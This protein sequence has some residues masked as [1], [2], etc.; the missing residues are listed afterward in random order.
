MS[1]VKWYEGL[2]YDLSEAYSVKK[3]RFD[4]SDWLNEIGVDTILSSQIVLD[5]GLTAANENVQ[6]TYVEYDISCSGATVG[7]ILIATCVI[8]TAGG[9]SEPRTINF[10]IIT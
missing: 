1:T 7:D 2:E 9:Q 10:R 4:W 5:T 8:T 3:F 6:S